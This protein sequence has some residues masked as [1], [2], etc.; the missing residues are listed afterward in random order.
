MLMCSSN[1]Y[2]EWSCCGSRDGTV[3]RCAVLVAAMA[4]VKER[5]KREQK[6]LELCGDKT[7]AEAMAAK[8][9]CCNFF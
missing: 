6:F 1:Q 4:K 9:S 8:V 7:R 5:E 3:E 2:Q